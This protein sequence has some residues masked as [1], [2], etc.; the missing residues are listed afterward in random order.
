[1]WSFASLGKHESS[2]ESS[3]LSDQ[4]R[5]HLNSNLELRHDC[6]EKQLLCLAVWQLPLPR[7][8]H[9]LKPL[10]FISGTAIDILLMS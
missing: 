10:S 3:G 4:L 1:M 9:I 2:R 6:I 5:I 8:W 7:V